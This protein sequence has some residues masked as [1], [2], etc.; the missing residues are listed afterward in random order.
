MTA[1][2]LDIVYLDR[3]SG[4][5]RR[6]PVHAARTL[7][8]LY[9]TTT[10][11][12]IL[13]LLTRTRTFSWLYGRLNELPLSRRR[14]EPFVAAMG[15]DLEG[16]VRS[17]NEY[18]SFAD[19]FTRE[20]HPWVRPVASGAG[21]CV[22][23][24]DGRVL[25]HPRVDASSEFPVKRARF[26]LST[27]LQD[28]GLTARL[29]G[30]AMAIVRLGMADYHHVHFPA[31]GV[32]QATRRLSGRYHAGGPYAR[33]WLVPFYGEN[34]RMLTPLASDA[35]GPVVMVEI[36][37]LAVGSVRQAFQ[38]GVRVERGQRKACF[39][40]GGS[41]VVLLFQA[42]AIRF[43]ADLEAASR[44]GLEVHLRMGERLG[45]A[46]RGASA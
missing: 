39:A 15:V 13:G 26:S 32:P 37:A 3:S 24:C 28:A 38:P 1:G 2:P 11:G 34:V 29:D 42:G 14:I 22:S 19:F 20:L 45:S 17:L 5:L 27:L 6:E 10:G 23:P 33:T 30:G 43:D 41:T 25:V 4:E 46:A 18:G 16:C 7:S 9:N 31:A 36:G 44:C 8:W 12:A 21:V 35:F 40:L